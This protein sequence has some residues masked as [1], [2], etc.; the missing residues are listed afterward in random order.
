MLQ[1]YKDQQDAKEE[2]S[3][4]SAPGACSKDIGQCVL[5]M[6]FC[7]NRRAEISRVAGNAKLSDTYREI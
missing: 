1:R 7:V 3:K 5:G 4:L 6:T 2:K